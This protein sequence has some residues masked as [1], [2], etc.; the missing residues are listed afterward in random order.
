MRASFPAAVIILDN[1]A[2]GPLISRPLQRAAGAA[3]DILIE[4]PS[5]TSA[6]SAS[7][8]GCLVLR[9]PIPNDP[10]DLPASAFFAGATE[11]RQRNREIVCRHRLMH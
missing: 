5:T 2:L 8:F 1:T 11:T 7:D 9:K 10:I 3:A 4:G 6:A